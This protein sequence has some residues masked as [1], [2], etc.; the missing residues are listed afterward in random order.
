MKKLLF[1]LLLCASAIMAN[2]QFTYPRWGTRLNGDNAAPGYFG[3]QIVFAL[4]VGVDTVTLNVAG[5]N[6]IVRCASSQ[7]GADV[8]L[9][10]SVC[11]KLSQSTNGK[12]KGYVGDMMTLSL[13]ADGTTRKV[14][15]TGDNV[16]AINTTVTAN[17]T[18]IYRLFYN[19]SKW[20]SAGSPIV[21]P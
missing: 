9:A 20:V 15:F 16:N 7:S 1:T 2:A 14:K 3:N 12:Y 17:K 6:T 18:L 11:F 8:S 4:G 13:V 21:A 5:Y 19:G 10:D